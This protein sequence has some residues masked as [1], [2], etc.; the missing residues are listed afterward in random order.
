MNDK[1]K[2][3]IHANLNNLGGAFSV[4]Y[5]AQK[6]LKDEYIFDYFSSEEFSKNDIYNHLVAMGSKCMGGVNYK[7]RLFKQYEVYKTFKDYLLTN[8]YDFVHIHADTAWKI[9]VYYLAAKKAGVDNIVV[10]S[11]SSG[12]NGHYKLINYI[13]HCITKGIVKKAKYKCACSD[14]AAKWMF[15]TSDDVRIIRNGV[16]IEKYKYNV[17][18]R[19]K[20][21]NDLGIKGKKVIG[22]VS[23]FSQQK[24]PKFIYKIIKQFK[25]NPEYA[26]LMVGNRKECILKEYIDEDRTIENVFFAG[27]VI[28]PQDYLSAMDVFI[29]PS[30]FEGLPMCALE[31]QVSGL[32]TFVSDK[33][34][35]QTQC[36]K[37]FERIELNEKKWK[38]EIDKK[39]IKYD[40]TQIN[41]FLDFEKASSSTMAE[42]FKELYSGGI[43]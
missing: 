19:E 14:I 12:I 9:S 29:L 43:L 22:T 35:M 25:D 34:S 18:S 5:E 40:R 11:H 24:N 16:D 39:S 6:Q 2:R 1:R 15:D 4:A 37:Y 20:I 28:N 27:M 3:I 38:N 36:S 31:A 21:R 10:H 41:N 7:N 23:D 13:L 33:V 42:K 30:K 32:Y 8:H 26:F 17:K